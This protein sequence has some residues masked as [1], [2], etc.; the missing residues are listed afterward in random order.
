MRAKLCPPGALCGR[1]MTRHMCVAALAA[2]AACSFVGASSAGPPGVGTSEVTIDFSNNST[3]DFEPLSYQS[4]GIVLPP[5]RCGS[6]GCAPWFVG[7]LQG[8]HALVGNPLR[9]GVEA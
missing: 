5:E 7:F 6:A 4:E 3:G 9:G 2:V 8:D 1:K